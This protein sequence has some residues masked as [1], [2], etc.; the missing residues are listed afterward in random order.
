MGDVFV[1]GI[2]GLIWSVTLKSAVDGFIRSGLKP[3]EVISRLNGDYLHREHGMQLGCV[4]GNYDLETGVLV[5]SSAGYPPVFIKQGERNYWLK[6][7]CPPA[8]WSMEQ[9]FNSETIHL[10]SGDLLRFM[11]NGWLF[12]ALRKA[13]VS[14]IDELLNNEHS[15]Q[16]LSAGTTFTPDHLDDEALS[17]VVKL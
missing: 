11:S 1:S 13:G 4:V 12:E 5:F 8:G 16:I 9:Q 10:K 17:L 6:S 14:E 3:H 7:N 15:F 2:A